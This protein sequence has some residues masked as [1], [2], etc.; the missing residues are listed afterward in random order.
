MAEKIWYTPPV[1]AEGA[2]LDGISINF[3]SSIVQA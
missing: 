1:R 3:V 2:D